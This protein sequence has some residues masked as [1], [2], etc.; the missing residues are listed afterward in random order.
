MWSTCSW[1]FTSELS[2]SFQWAR[3]KERSL[4]LKIAVVFLGNNMCV[5]QT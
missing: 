3:E 1:L 5:V 4:L 2:V